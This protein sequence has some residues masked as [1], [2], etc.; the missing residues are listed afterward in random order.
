MQFDRLCLVRAFMDSGLAVPDTYLG[1]PKGSLADLQE[2]AY[3]LGTADEDGQR[4]VNVH[5]VQT[6]RFDNNNRELIVPEIKVMPTRRQLANGWMELLSSYV[7][8]I[9]TESGKARV[10]A[11]YD[12]MLDKGETM[13]TADHEVSRIVPAGSTVITMATVAKIRKQADG[14]MR[15][16]NAAVVVGRPVE[17]IWMRLA[18]QFE[19]LKHKHDV[20][21]E[22]RAK[23]KDYD[24]E[25]EI[26][27]ADT[28]IRYFFPELFGEERVA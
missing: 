17:D 14:E 10:I 22:V 28:L 16:S 8:F 7:R 24:K 4:N 11:I 15:T 27:H 23:Y 2:I 3:L 18:N 6:R 21:A 19:S 1:V 5:V 13:E 20:F 26:Y 12:E 25:M 9:K